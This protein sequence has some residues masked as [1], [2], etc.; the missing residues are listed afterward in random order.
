[1]RHAPQV[2]A[3]HS[4]CTFQRP[5]ASHG[6]RCEGRA[7]PSRREGPVTPRGRKYKY[8]RRAPHAARRRRATAT[9][10]PHHAPSPRRR[11]PKAPKRATRSKTRRR[12]NASTMLSPKI[13]ALEEGW[14]NEIKAKA[15]DVLASA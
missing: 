8:E 15:I 6:S 11:R 9:A 1:M 13:I 3:S 12:A 2:A 4:C 14:N 5:L 7:A 10:P